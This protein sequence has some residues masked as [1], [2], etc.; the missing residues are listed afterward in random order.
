MAVSDVN[1]CW[2]V[3]FRHREISFPTPLVPGQ[4]N[5]KLL[6]TQIRSSTLSIGVIWSQTILSQTINALDNSDHYFDSAAHRRVANVALQHGF[7]YYP[8]VYCSHGPLASYAATLTYGVT[9]YATLYSAAFGPYRR[10]TAATGNAGRS[11]LLPEACR[12]TT[13]RNGED[14][15]S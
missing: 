15:R 3:L 11:H 9:S 5:L 10:R 1:D 12:V 13:G 4:W 8:V 14:E 6:G 7:G 2:V